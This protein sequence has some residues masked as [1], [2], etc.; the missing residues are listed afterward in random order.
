MIKKELFD[1]YGL[2]DYKFK[3]CEDYELW[4]RIT[5]KIKIGYLDKPLIKKHGGH[6]GQLSDKYWGI[7]RYRIKALEKVLIINNLKNKQK[8]KVLNILLKKINII[9]LEASNTNNN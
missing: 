6:Q 9:L 8:L 4:L 2:F 1:K 3:V 7:D 5:S